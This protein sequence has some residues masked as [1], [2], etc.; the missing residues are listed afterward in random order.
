VTEV[1]SCR[2]LAAETCVQS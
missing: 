1:V 2:L